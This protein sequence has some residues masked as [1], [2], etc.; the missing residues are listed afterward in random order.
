[1]HKAVSLLVAIVLSGCAEDTGRSDQSQPQHNDTRD[2]LPVMPISA[3]AM[4]A[5]PPRPE[6]SV[7]PG[8]SPEEFPP[9]GHEKVDFISLP[10]NVWTAQS[11]VEL[12]LGL[13]V[14]P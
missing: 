3:E 13:L 14:T 12:L 9:M 8:F 5:M 7:A 6:L 4:P 2:T 11:K 10:N 1:M